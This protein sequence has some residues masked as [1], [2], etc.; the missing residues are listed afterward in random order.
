MAMAIKRKA[1]KVLIIHCIIFF[2]PAILPI[3]QSLPF[4]I[5]LPKE[6][7]IRNR[8]C[9]LLFI[10]KQGMTGFLLSG[11][12]LSD[13]AEEIKNTARVTPLV[14][15]PRDQLDKVIVKRDTS[16]GIEDG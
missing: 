8:H 14:I 2:D 9:S 12:N 1:S 7:A 13:V 10:I 11:I 15:V 16:G 6:T 3:H 5:S 4:S